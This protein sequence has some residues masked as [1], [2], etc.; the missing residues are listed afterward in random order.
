MGHV[1]PREHLPESK[2]EQTIRLTPITA[3][4]HEAWLPV[5]HPL[6]R[7]R[8]GGRQLAAMFCAVVFFVV[9]ALAMA[10][11]V[12]APE[13]ENHRLAEFPSPM[14]GWEFFVGL[15]NWATDHL[16]FR[17]S[18]VHSADGISRGVFG[19]PPPSDQTQRVPLQVPHEPTATDT[20]TDTAQT[21]LD[22][23]S[24]AAGFPKV[25]EGKQGWLYLGFDIQGKCRPL[26]A[27]DDILA[28]LRRLRDAVL[29]SGRQFILIVP[30]DKSTIVTEF[31]PD[32]YVGKS[33]AQAASEVFWQRV[34]G[35]I[36][37][38]DLR[39]NLLRI[40]EAGGP[41]YRQLDTHWDDRGALMMVRQLADHIEPGITTGW[42]I[43]PER[44]NRY[45]ADL[46]RMLGR[47]GY[48]DVQ[49]YSLSPDGRHDQTRP[50]AGDLRTPLRV[51]SSVV[52]G[53]VSTPIGIL[54]DSF[55]LSTSRY[56]PAAFSDVDVVFY[57]A[58]KSNPAAVLDVITSNDVV[59]FEI[60]E[61]NLA[62]GAAT[63]IQPAMVDL[64]IRHLK[65]N[66]RR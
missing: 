39:A 7:P 16:P 19:E 3:E 12:R 45:K 47:D 31:L 27:M 55:V 64:I 1:S 56:L 29:R 21:Q 6:H 23:P 50:P 34:T 11:G 52:D 44:V 22:E 24:T 8:H 13:N 28:N 20:D 9:P 57:Q 54:S 37:I 53:M 66:P 25:I 51:R 61:R 58:L 63:V 35:E 5:D 18:A 33:C 43:A 36:G 38:I 59:A 65:A 17:D 60:V 15:P 42:K 40:S 46:S 10:L 2:V 30:P 48:G 26:Q 4:S 32:T 62:S 49:L 41:P 14:D